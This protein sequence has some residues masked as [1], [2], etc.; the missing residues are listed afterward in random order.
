MKFHYLL[1]L[2]LLVSMALAIAINQQY[3]GEN[4]IDNI[5]VTYTTALPIHEGQ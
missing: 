4:N 5:L 3:A 2:P 1:D